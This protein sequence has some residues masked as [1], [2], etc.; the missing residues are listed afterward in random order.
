[1]SAGPAPTQGLVRDRLVPFLPAALYMAL[2]WGLS[3]MSHAPSTEQLPFKDKGAHFTEYALLSLFLC[4]GLRGSGLLTRLR[5]TAL[6]A[7]G[8]TAFWGLL[9]EIHQA[10]VPGRSSDVRDLF[11]DAI[12]ALIGAGLWV[13]FRHLRDRQPR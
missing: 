4:H 12:G 1:M 7:V 11:A 13:T 6:F 2:I 8:L 3:S 5:S 10:Y 9:D